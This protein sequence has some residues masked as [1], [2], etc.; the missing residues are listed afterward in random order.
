[1]LAQPAR[2]AGGDPGAAWRALHVVPALGARR[3]PLGRALLR[4][5]LRGYH[6]LRRRP[7]GRGRRAAR[8]TPDRLG[9][10]A[11]GVGED[12][13]RAGG[14][15]RHRPRGPARGAP[16][17]RAAA[18]WVSTTSASPC[19]VRRR[20]RRRCWSSSARSAYRS[21]SC[22]ACRRSPAAA[23]STRPRTSGSAPSASRS[24]AWRCAS[25]TTE[26]LLVRGP[27]AMRGYR[28]EPQKTAET[29]DADGWLHTGDIATIDDDGYVTIVDR[30]KEP[31]H[32]RRWQEHVAGQHRAGRQGLPPPDRAGR[33]RRRPA[34]LQ[35]GAD[36]SRPRRLRGV[37]RAGR[38]PRRVDH[39]AR[40][41]PGCGP[42]DRG[43]R[44]RC[45][46]AA[47]PDRAGQAL[48]RARHGL[49]AGR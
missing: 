31:D 21:A 46:P 49:A 13:G 44:G 30:K 22:G 3:R 28:N 8:G 7:Q 11:A 17:R 26:S 10:G 15:G 4:D 9:R 20:S 12:Q 6:H 34:P 43:R 2:G 40:R 39:G 42:A 37:R 29:I 1:M 36:R 35:R 18:C 19:P 41:R 33:R 32:Q 25:A 27:Q 23:R 16:R 48:P 24:P 47:V 45:E 38:P 5:G 14:Q